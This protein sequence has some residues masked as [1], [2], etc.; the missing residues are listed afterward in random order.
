MSPKK[1]AGG[2]TGFLRKY[3]RLIVFSALTAAAAAVGH[4]IVS[5]FLRDGTG[6]AFAA[7]VCFSCFLC[8]CGVFVLGAV[9][10]RT[11]PGLIFLALCAL[12][13]TLTAL[14][15]YVQSAV[16]GAFTPSVLRFCRVLPVFCIFCFLWLRLT[17]LT[18]R[19][20][21]GVNAALLVIAMILNLT[22]IKGSYE[23]AVNP[24]RG[25]LTSWTL[26]AMIAA[27][28]ILGGVN[29]LTAEDGN[30]RYA[31]FFLCLAV[32]LPVSL[33]AWGISALTGGSIASAVR[34]AFTGFAETR[35]PLDLIHLFTSVLLT[36]GMI[37]ALADTIDDLAKPGAEMQALA[38]RAKYAADNLQVM[39]R[40]Q[41]ETRAE[42]HEMRHHMLLLNEMLKRDQAQRAGEYVRFLMDRVD[43]LPTG[44]YSDNI[45]INAIAGHYLNNAKAE[46]IAVTTDIHATEKTA[47]PDEE[48]CVLLTN[49]LENA[50]EAAVAMREDKERFIRLTFRS[51]EEHLTVTCVNSTDTEV[52]VTPDGTVQTSKADAKHHGYGIAAMKRVVDKHAGI[53]T[54]SCADGTFTVKATV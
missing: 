29:V 34:E 54:V 14:G 35:D 11:D 49:M 50:F 3:R 10:G 39:L 41:E 20:A 25:A 43:A 27:L 13:L 9:R 24:A 44:T 4:A 42:R 17:G 46:G 45:I 1:N 15:T 37:C 47:L 32:V 5:V 31:R 51:S 7:G 23:S 33:A 22:V 53:F 12:G 40:A 21:V 19:I 26:L 30:P 6:A 28:L 2:L 16:F 38:L 8:I 18:F 36:G 52:N 48:L